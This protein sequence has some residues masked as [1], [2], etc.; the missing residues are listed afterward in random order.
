[1]MKMKYQTEEQ[2]ELLK[3]G[4]VLLIVVG[5]ILGVFLL[6]KV[7]IK[8]EAK[9]IEYQSGSVSTTTAIVGTML[10]QKE[11][12]YYVLAYDYNSDLGA[13]YRNAASNYSAGE[14]KL[15]VYFLDLNNAFNNPYYVKENSNPKATSL[16]DLRIKDG[17]L[18][19]I[20]NGKI[21]EY[22]EGSEKI[23]EKFKTGK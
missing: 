22:I 17:T 10:N 20:K 12:E 21:A 1:M 23:L 8:P 15:K 19:R 4:I 6:S 11:E 18:I 3:F 13:S 2:K 9:E 7:L 14:K 16:K 5:L